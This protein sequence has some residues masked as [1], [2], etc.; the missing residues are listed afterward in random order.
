VR[1]SLNQEKSP[2]FRQQKRPIS[3]KKEEENGQFI[4][5]TI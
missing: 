2:S 1:F 3:G 4:F 5:E